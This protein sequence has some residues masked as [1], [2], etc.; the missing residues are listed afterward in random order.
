MSGRLAGGRRLRPCRR[1]STNSQMQQPSQVGIPTYPYKGQIM[2][3]HNTP[4]RAAE[5]AGALA[6]SRVDRTCRPLQ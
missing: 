2:T 4:A 6:Q 5:A 3:G 1:S